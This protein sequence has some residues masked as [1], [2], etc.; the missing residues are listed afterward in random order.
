MEKIKHYK[1]IA[2]AVLSREVYYCAANSENIIDI[3]ILRQGLHDI[4]EKKMSARL[5]EEID[6]VD[7]K[8]YDAILLAYGLCN[9]G[10]RGLHSQ[11]PLVIPRAHDCITLLMGSKA[12]YQ[13]YFDKYPGTFYQSIGWLEHCEDTASN[14]ESTTSLMGIKTY[15]DYVKEYGEENAKYLIEAM[16]GGLNHYERLT[17]IETNVGNTEKHKI[18]VKKSAQEKSWAYDEFKGN[19]NI[20]QKLM[21]G[22]WDND[23]F[24]TLKSDQKIDAS[25]DDKV[26]KGKN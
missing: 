25:Y 22:N 21:S 10:I 9:N 26:I 13:E 2:C 4:G 23:I 6:S 1:L 24:L 8:Q 14:P 3:T 11:I 15:E 19:K 18:E 16:G 7:T 12:K 20:L 5:Q 17:F